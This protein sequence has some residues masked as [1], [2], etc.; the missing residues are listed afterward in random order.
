VELIT[1][2]SSTVPVQI[3]RLIKD[4]DTGHVEE[5]ANVD[6]AW[7]KRDNGEGGSCIS[8][9]PITLHSLV[10]ENIKHEFGIW[11]WETPRIQTTAGATTL[12]VNG[13]AI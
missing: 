10:P 11:I 3:S 6:V 9:R 1:H 7:T 8:W 2:A 5:I 12:V 13:L 4:V